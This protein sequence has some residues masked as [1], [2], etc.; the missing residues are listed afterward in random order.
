MITQLKGALVEKTPTHLVIDCQG[1]GYEVNISLYTFGQI[2]DEEK[3]KL[4]T[5]L[6]IREDAH[7]LFG[8]ATEL[9]RSVFRLLISVS[10][11]GTSIARTMLSSLTPEEVKRAILDEDFNR[12]KGVKGIGLKTSQRLIIELKDKVNNLYGIEQIHQKSNNT[13]KEETL[14][15]LEVLGYNRRNS[16]KVIDNLIQSHSETSIEE[17]I[18]LALNKL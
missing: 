13:T 16:E 2:K 3:I 15:A 14:S 9:E 6:Q 17:L 10:G 7:V 11:I 1:V 5:H 8:F 18:K 4:F 12:I